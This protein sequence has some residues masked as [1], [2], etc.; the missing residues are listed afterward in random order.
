MSASKDLAAGILLLL[1]HFPLVLRKKK[2]C[3][4]TTFAIGC[5]VNVKEA[6]RMKLDSQAAV[7]RESESEAVLVSQA[8]VLQVFAMV[9]LLKRN[10]APS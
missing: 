7:L 3:E 9:L 8:A 5:G 6:S 4:S 10:A 2:F 1:D